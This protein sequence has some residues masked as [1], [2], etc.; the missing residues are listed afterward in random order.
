MRSLAATLLALLTLC[1][2]CATWLE[3]LEADIRCAGLVH[4]TP[5]HA[6]HALHAGLRPYYCVLSCTFIVS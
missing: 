5:P 1:S 2:A 6:F 4:I 3:T